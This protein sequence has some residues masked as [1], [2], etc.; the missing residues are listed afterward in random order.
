MSEALPILTREEIALELL[1]RDLPPEE[2]KLAVS[3]VV[4]IYGV[5]GARTPEQLAL[6]ADWQE[7]LRTL[8]P[9]YFS[10]KFGEHHIKFWD[11]AWG[12]QLGVR[13][14]PE[15]D[16]WPRGQGKSTN[17]EA[18]CAAW[19]ARG[20]RRYVWYICETQEQADDHVQNVAAM[21]ESDEVQ[22][23]Y[24]HL[25]KRLVNK[26]G[27]SKGWKRN[28]IRT[29][30]GFTADALGLD[31]AKRGVKLEEQRPDGEIFDDVDGK[32]DSPQVTQKK[33]DI[34]TTSILPAGSY[35]CSVLGL[36][37]LIHKD[38][39]FSQLEDGRADWLIDRY[40][41]GPIPALRNFDYEKQPDGRTRITSGE[42]TWEGMDVASC[43]QK[44][45]DWGL[46]A[47]L[48]ECQHKVELNLPGAIFPE[49]S[50]VYHVITE[51]EFKAFYGAVAWQDPANPHS[52]CQLPHNWNLGRGLDWGTTPGH[53][54][55][56]IFAA[57]PYVTHPLTDSAFIYREITR[58]VWPV[59]E[60]GPQPVSPRR[61]K[62]AIM[63]STKR[64]NEEARMEISAM[65]HEASAAYNTF[66]EMMGD[67]DSLWFNK[68]KPQVGSG[69]P[70]I[71]N[72][73]EIDQTQ[74]HPFRRYPANYPDKALAGSPLAGRPRFYV[75]VPDKQGELYCD[76]EGTLRV[77]GAVDSAGMARLRYEIPKYRNP[78]TAT[79][80][81]KSR[82]NPKAHGEDDAIDA[83]KGLANVFFPSIEKLSK[84]EKL[85]ALLPNQLKIA[86]INERRKA[87]DNVQ[88]A[89]SR[90]THEAAKL[91]KKLNRG[92]TYSPLAD[93]RKRLKQGK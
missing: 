59:Q 19:A 9:K 14:R 75:I 4:V 93:Y 51:S 24:P 43:Q 36:Q 25:G 41:S 54:M 69:V 58:P 79:G 8:F 47:F 31:V 67:D 16:I 88:G 92:K 89:I 29:A 87:G 22:E 5:A 56:C 70:Q 39:I 90:R 12:I 38:S 57:R 71:Q 52:P 66:L 78:I 49:W 6:E 68:W 2:F 53:L 64:L 77:R 15:I 61:V 32:H 7:W 84:E 73:L 65:S 74:E 80:Q 30:S 55:A 62:K 37:N 11:W 1:K 40:V 60:G 3:A 85:D 27:T 48:T 13:S 72:M 18:A 81:E 17:G 10:H 42:P 76:Q 63:D 26:F 91:E 50:E 20:T 23:Y 83:L 82:P 35:D 46:R 21:L 45:N 44:I 86:T 34:I 28:R 33:I